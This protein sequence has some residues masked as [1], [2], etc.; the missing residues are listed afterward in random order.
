MTSR[1]RYTHRA[2]GRH[3][4]TADALAIKHHVAHPRL[5]QE[6]QVGAAAGLSDQVADPGGTL[7]GAFVDTGNGAE[8]SSNSPFMPGTKE[9][10]GVPTRCDGR[11]KVDPLIHGDA[12]R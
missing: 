4:N 12:A 2:I 5:Q 3:L 9:C 7:R 6:S 8:P 10:P 1:C 11:G